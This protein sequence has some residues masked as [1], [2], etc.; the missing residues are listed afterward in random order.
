MEIFNYHFFINAL[1]GSFLTSIIC[2]VIGSYIVAKRLT[3]VSGGLAHASFGGLG[4]GYFLGI[5]PILTG[6]IFS[7]FSAVGVEWI[8]TKGMRSDS[9]IA[10]FWAVGM[11]MGI[12]FIS[13]VPGY[14]PDLMSYLFGN[15]LSITNAELIG[16]AVFSVLLIG[17]V[18]FNYQKILY[19][20][21]DEE[22]AL[23]KGMPVAFIKYS[24]I[25][26]V[27]ITVVLCVKV[28]GLILILSLLTLPQETANLFTKEM[29]HIMVISSI[30]AF[31]A[32]L[33][34]LY[35][36]YILNLPTGA[37]IIIFLALVYGVCRYGLS[38][39]RAQKR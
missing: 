32:S 19:V 29:K 13:L 9:V 22:F 12:V 36:S 1:I 28:S 8:T 25:I 21:F 3:F 33:V 16:I 37:V 6:V 27:G 4:L 15:I 11:S 24:L 18:V 39:V 2:G 30:I 7:A 5:N 17:F 20:A 23:T 34:G 14:A 35:F 31:C 26:F 38:V 10:A